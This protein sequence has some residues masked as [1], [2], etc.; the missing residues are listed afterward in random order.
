MESDSKKLLTFDL[1]ELEKKFHQ[2]PTNNKIFQY[3]TKWRQIT[4]FGIVLKTVRDGENPLI[5][6]KWVQPN[7]KR[8]IKLREEKNKMFPYPHKLMPYYTL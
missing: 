3:P 1:K 5:A 6:M 2:N 8:T 4:L 7:E